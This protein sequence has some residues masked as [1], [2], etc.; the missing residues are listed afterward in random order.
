MGKGKGEIL[1]RRIK[2][3]IKNY[4]KQR[5]RRMI[6]GEIKILLIVLN[7]TNNDFSIETRMQRSKC[8]ADYYSTY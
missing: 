2:A 5:L 6:H 1:K 8:F 7:D 4:A 3:G